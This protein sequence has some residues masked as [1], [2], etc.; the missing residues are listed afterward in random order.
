MTRAFALETTFEWRQ[1]KADDLKS[2]KCFEVDKETRGDKYQNIVIKDKCKTDDLVYAFNY[3]TGHCYQF[4]EGTSGK[5]YFAKVNS[6]FCKPK[7]TKFVFTKIKNSSACYELDT[8]TLGKNYYKRVDD[9][10]C[11]ESVK[12]LWEQ[13]NDTRGRCY[14]IGSL[15]G[16]MTKVVVKPKECRPEKT[17]FQ[18]VRLGPF[19]GDCV[20]SHPTDPK[21]YFERTDIEKCMPENTLFIFYKEDDV[22][23]GKCYQVDEETRGDKYLDEVS[24]SKCKEI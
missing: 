22:S 17:I 21:L 10:L 18:F 19:K 20:E 13:R 5:K 12:Y 2:G 23:K 9:D 3:L 7:K 14:K 16:E 24:I 11:K 8:E 15:G 1:T 4:D 6:D